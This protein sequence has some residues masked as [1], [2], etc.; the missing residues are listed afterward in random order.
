[1]ADTRPETFAFRM[2]R[3]EA[4]LKA[5]VNSKLRRAAAAVL[6]TVVTATRVDT[7]FARANWIVT[8]RNPSTRIVYDFPA[9]PKRSGGPTGS[10][11]SAITISRGMD[12]I[13]T[14]TDRNSGLWFTNNV[15]YISVINYKYGDYMVE[16]AIIAGESALKVGRMFL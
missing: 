11:V 2:L 8:K 5:G 6:T 14:L 7:G 16:K 10:A 15:P 12:V 3:R 9:S 4:Q 1:M 13:R